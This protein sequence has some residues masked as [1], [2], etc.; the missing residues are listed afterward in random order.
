MGLEFDSRGGGG[1]GWKAGIPW[2]VNGA[3]LHLTF[4]YHIPSF[5]TDIADKNL[6][7]K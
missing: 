3:Q 7:R 4:H 5:M 6:S 2:I 1:G